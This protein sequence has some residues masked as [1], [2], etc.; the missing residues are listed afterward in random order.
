MI[1]FDY[2][3]PMWDDTVWKRNPFAWPS[4]VLRDAALQMLAQSAMAAVTLKLVPQPR[5]LEISLLAVGGADQ[6]SGLGSWTLRNLCAL[7]DLYGVDLRLEV[8]SV[9]WTGSAA[10]SD[11]EL[12]AWYGRYGFVGEEAAGDAAEGVTV[13]DMVRPC[14]K[15]APG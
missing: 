13:R 9:P 4:V 15:R 3:L 7:A 12:A 1:D 11:D 5:H 10:M 8:S 2:C 6:G 14:A